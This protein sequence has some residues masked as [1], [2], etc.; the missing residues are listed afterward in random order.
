MEQLFDFHKMGFYDSALYFKKKKTPLRRTQSY[1]IELYVTER[2]I[3][4]IDENKYPHKMGNILV[5]RPG[6]LR[7]SEQRFACYYIHFT[8]LD[9]VFEQKYLR[10]LP[11][12]MR[13]PDFEKMRT[14]IT[15]V[16]ECMATEGKE[17][18]FYVSVKLLNLICALNKLQNQQCNENTKY[19]NLRQNIYQAQAFI[20]RHFS[21]KILLEQIAKE[22]HLSPNYFLAVFKSLNGTTPNRYITQV[23][24]NEA[25]KR[26]VNT[27]DSMEKIAEYCGFDS[28]A[29]MCYVFKKILKISPKAY[30]DLYRKIL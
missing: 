16:A 12:C 6:M 1:E 19:Y 24:L 9:R 29:Y 18:L 23:R 30:R 14:C 27:A 28:Q 21:E 8:C 26:L 20:Q 25:K 4:Y 7:Q 13:T 10:N 15:D 3:S 17:N 5:C 22:A 2:G 11:V